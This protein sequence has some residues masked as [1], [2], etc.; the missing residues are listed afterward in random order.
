MSFEGLSSRH[1]PPGR[2][3]HPASHESRAARTVIPERVWSRKRPSSHAPGRRFRGDIQRV[4]RE[5]TKER[6]NWL[7]EAKRRLAQAAG[8]VSGV[9]DKH[10]DSKLHWKMKSYIWIAYPVMWQ[11]STNFYK[12]HHASRICC[13]K[14]VIACDG[15]RTTCRHNKFETGLRKSKE[16]NVLT[17]W[18]LCKRCNDTEGDIRD[19]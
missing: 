13:H 11:S 10:G 7:Q 3:K 4:Q 2:G 18:Q 14:Q 6:E 19:L 17:L 12:R 8:L 16:E 5:D 9:G 15:R 1:D